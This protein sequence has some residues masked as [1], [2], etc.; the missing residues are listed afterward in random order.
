M[1]CQDCGWHQGRDP[2]C[3]QT[4]RIMRDMGERVASLESDLAAAKRDSANAGALTAEARN[5]LAVAVERIAELEKK[6]DEARAAIPTT[7]VKVAIGDSIVC[8][9]PLSIVANGWQPY[10]QPHPGAYIQH[11]FEQCERIDVGGGAQLIVYRGEK[12]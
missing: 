4:G 7:P 11:R 9:Y 6:N 8:F 3:R 12:S 10:N 5:D 2:S 1:S